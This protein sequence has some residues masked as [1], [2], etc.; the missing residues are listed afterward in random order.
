MST[1]KDWKQIFERAITDGPNQPTHAMAFII[2]LSQ[3]PEN[4][5]PYDPNERDRIGEAC[6]ELAQRFLG[7][8]TERIRD[9]I[10]QIASQYIIFDN[11]VWV[12]SNI[13]QLFF[14]FLLIFISLNMWCRAL[15]RMGFMRCW[16][17]ERTSNVISVGNLHPNPEQNRV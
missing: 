9:L 6:I 13:E 12:L 11:Y 3:F 14:H 16:K 7:K 15:N 5:T 17:R 2:L 1:E 10:N 8:I 4:A